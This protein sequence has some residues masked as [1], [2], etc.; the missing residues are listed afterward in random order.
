MIVHNHDSIA[1]R[2]LQLPSV[3]TTITVIHTTRQNISEQNLPAMQ[4]QTGTIK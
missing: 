3:V 2:G 4:K 1:H